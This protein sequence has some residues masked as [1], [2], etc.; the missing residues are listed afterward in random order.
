MYATVSCAL[1][2]ESLFRLTS[3][4][5]HSN[6]WDAFGVNTDHTA[7]QD[8]SEYKHKVVPLLY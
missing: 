5:A 4:F 6:S 2:L 3:R 1:F 8:F 7:D